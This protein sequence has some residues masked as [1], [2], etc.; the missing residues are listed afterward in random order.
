[1]GRVASQEKV[2]YA[3]FEMPQTKKNALMRTCTSDNASCSGHF[4][5]INA[6][7]V[8]IIIYSSQ[9]EPFILVY[10]ADIPPY[11]ALTC[12]ESSYRHFIE[13]IH[14]LLTTK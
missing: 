8:R 3:K 1:M 13:I 10:K 4:F 6:N 9:I 12:Q 11:R 5:A 14:S 7:F 2:P